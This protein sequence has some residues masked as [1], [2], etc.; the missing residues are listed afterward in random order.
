MSLLHS[1]SP[2]QRG[3]EMASLLPCCP[4][5]PRGQLGMAGVCLQ[6]FCLLSTIDVRAE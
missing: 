4:D 3:L 1:S 2:A 6:G 5:N